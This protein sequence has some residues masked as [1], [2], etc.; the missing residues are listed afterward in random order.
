VKGH[1]LDASNES[2]HPVRGEELNQMPGLGCDE[3][4]DQKNGQNVEKDLPEGAHTGETIT[5][6][7]PIPSPKPIPS[8]IL[9]K[10]TIMNAKT[11]GEANP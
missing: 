1:S 8:S 3:R 10:L 6:V 9:S 11:S 4:P 7:T 2:P 5:L